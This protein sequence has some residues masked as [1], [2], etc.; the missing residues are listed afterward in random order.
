[1]TVWQVDFSERPLSTP[2]GQTLWELLIVDPN[3]Q[4]LHQAQCSQAQARF[5][6]LIRQLELCINNTG[7]CPERIQLF[8]PQCLS[9]FEAA[10]NE[11]NLLVE[12]TRYTPAL[13]QVLATQA[14]TYSTAPNYT[15]DAYQPLQIMP[16]PPVPLPDQLWGEG[17]RF[18]GLRAKELETHLIVQPIPILSLRM[19]LLPSQLGLGTNLIIPGVIIYGGRRSMALARWCQEQNPAEVTFIAGQPDGV[20]M[21]AGLR[22]RWILA[23]FDDPQVKQA[24]QVFMAR[25]KAAQGLHFLIIQPDES[26]ITYTGLWLLQQSSSS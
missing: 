17:W 12:P 8:R 7:S 4:I 24:A 3:G 10:A 26:G 23:T 21:A 19:D 20:I 6:W 25:Q 16:L 15:G 11:L 14:S 2:Q 22:E 9:L 18:T 1:M 5:D 13:K